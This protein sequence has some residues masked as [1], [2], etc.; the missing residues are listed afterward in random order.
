MAVVHMA[1]TIMVR[2]DT[3]EEFYVDSKAECHAS[4]D[5]TGRV[6]KFSLS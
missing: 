5:V 6:L 4:G 2:Y 3:I 1:Y